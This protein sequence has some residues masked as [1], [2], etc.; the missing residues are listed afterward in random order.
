MR[1]EHQGLGA[2]GDRSLAH[3][4][5][6]GVRPQRGDGVAGASLDPDVWRAIG[7]AEHQQRLRPVLRKQLRQFAIHGLVGHRKNVT[8]EFDI[9][10]GGTA[11]AQQ[12]RHQRLRRI[13][14]RAG[15]RAEAGNEDTEFVAQFFEPFAVMPANAGIQ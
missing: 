4:R 6:V 11:Q 1:A 14:G 12:P 8:G 7:E 3:P 10:Q 5:V 13:K 15:K 2:A 9:A